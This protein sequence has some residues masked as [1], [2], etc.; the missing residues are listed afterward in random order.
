MDW[1]GNFILKQWNLPYIKND[2]DIYSTYSLAFGNFM[3]SNF[4]NDK[5]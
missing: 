3:K 4:Y 1:I 5:M 2:C